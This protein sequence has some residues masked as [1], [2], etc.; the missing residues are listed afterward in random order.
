M[1]QGVTRA[2]STTHRR[3]KENLRG[4]RKARGSE[5]LKTIPVIEQERVE[6]GKIPKERSQGLKRIEKKG[7][8][9]GKGTSARMQSTLETKFYPLQLSLSLSISANRVQTTTTTTTTQ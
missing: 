7:S 3:E 2:I 4:L 5:W 9:E 1:V 8:P 6:E